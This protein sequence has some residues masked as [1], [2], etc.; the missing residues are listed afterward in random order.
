MITETYKGKLFYVIGPSGA[1]KDTLINFA[2]QNTAP[3]TPVLFAHRYIT[4]EVDHTGENHIELSH[5]EFKVRKA[6]GLFALD[7]E[8]HENKYGIGIEIN[9]WMENGMNVVMNGSRGYLEK[10]LEKYPSLRVILISVS[11]HVLWDRLKRRGR[12]NDQEIQKRIERSK[13]FNSLA[14]DQYQVIHVKN[15]G[16]IEEAGGLFVEAIKSGLVLSPVKNK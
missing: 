8:S 13:E 6:Q 15:D 10:A 2:R 3:G 9:L 11:E 4:R 7:W 16:S 1:G 14:V 12:E 5:T